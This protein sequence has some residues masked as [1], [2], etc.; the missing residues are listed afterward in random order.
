MSGHSKWK[1]IKHKKGAADAKRSSQ[2]TRLAHAITIAAKSGKGLDIAVE[3]AKKVNMPKDNIDRAIKR[4][5][6]E[7]AG[8]E[9]I[10]TQ[11]EAYG[12]AGVGII[13][14]VLT[15]NKNRIISEIKAV[16]NKYGGK[17]ASGGAVSYL[18]EEKGVIELKKEGQTL[19]GEDLEMVIIESGAN[20]Y[21]A[22]DDII[23][24]YT[25]PKEISNVK[26]ALEF[27][28]LKVENS[29]VEMSPKNYVAIP[30]DKKESLIKILEALEDL[31]DVDEV[32][33]NADL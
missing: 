10:E 21:T 6:G 14:K 28:A 22:V 16:L 19:S 5:T 23:Y 26:K 33:T 24:I 32:F 12:P 8:E 29:Q 4:G 7:L 25:D 15:D 18:F 13:I 2:F 17:L 9:I 3:Q 11:Y 1:Q 20:D 30:E 31:D 27:K